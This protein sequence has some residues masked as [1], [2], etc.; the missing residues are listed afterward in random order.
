MGN[1]GAIAIFL[2]VLIMGMI[3]G[4][5][6]SNWFKGLQLLIVFLLIALLCYFLPNNVSSK[7]IK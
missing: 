2:S 6:R 1:A 4:D 7:A 5:G 3:A